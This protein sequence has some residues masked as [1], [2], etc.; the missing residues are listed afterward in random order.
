MAS[1]TR[2]GARDDKDGSVGSSKRS[3][4][5][6]ISQSS[7]RNQPDDNDR[8]S[9]RPKKTPNPFKGIVNQG[10]KMV[11]SAF[12]IAD[13]D[14]VKAELQMEDSEATTWNSVEQRTSAAFNTAQG[15]GRSPRS[16]AM[17]RLTERTGKSSPASS[18]KRYPHDIY[19]YRKAQ[20][21]LTERNT[22]QP[23]PGGVA[24]SDF[25]Y[26]DSERGL[27]HHELHASSVRPSYDNGRNP[28]ELP[29]L[30]DL[31]AADASSSSSP[32]SIHACQR[33]CQAIL[34]CLNPLTLVVQLLRILFHSTM[35]IAV[36]FF[37]AAWVLFYSFDNPSSDAIPVEGVSLS[38]WCNFVGRQLLMLEVARFA[39]YIFIDVIVFSTRYGRKV[40]NSWLRFTLVE[41]YGYPFVLTLW[42]LLDL[43]LLQGS[44]RFQQ[45]WLYWSGVTIYSSDNP[46]GYMLDSEWYDRILSC[47]LVV[48]IATTIKRVW[49][50]ISFGQRN[51]ATY[52]PTFEKLLN[53]VILL[54]EIADLAQ[55][56]E[57]V[58]ADDTAVSVA[59]KDRKSANIKWQS[60]RFDSN[61]EAES[62][63]SLA[64]ADQVEEK[65][66]EDP[67][68]EIFSPL[69]SETISGPSRLQNKRQ[70]S[71]LLS[72]LDQWDDS[73]INDKLANEV[74]SI[75]GP[76]VVSSL[77]IND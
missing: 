66:Q 36:L 34:R 11:G 44:H 68:D 48:G 31:Q 45:N 51:T 52:Q 62:S 63:K 70:S 23:R 16:Q 60:M 53:E 6:Q 41:A 42:G 26:L 17:G 33:W 5:V 64:K 32:P 15:N 1:R 39:Q 46:G 56:A 69:S 19:E 29:L 8:Q 25:Y 21:L 58:S 38:R 54:A 4:S 40:M 57:A 67:S 35:W 71:M 9:S 50:R 20:E 22:R 2:Q 13:K 43:M 7:A 65:E 27:A 49:I 30:A 59:P 75:L 77:R 3:S 10:A 47:V 24:W 73:Q 14:A 12:G 76:A 61:A 37:T 18:N 28:E 72:K 74:S 55:S